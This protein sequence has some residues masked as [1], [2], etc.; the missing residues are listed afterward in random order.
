MLKEHGRLEPAKNVEMAKL[1]GKKYKCEVCGK[2]AV[3]TNVEFGTALYCEECGGI[4]NED[5][6]ESSTT[7]NFKEKGKV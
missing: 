2:E 7:I 5:F 3:L 6:M 1:K 4:L